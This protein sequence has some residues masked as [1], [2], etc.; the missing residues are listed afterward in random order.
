VT[1][2]HRRRL[3]AGARALAGLEGRPEPDEVRLQH[4]ASALRAA[5]RAGGGVVPRPEFE[6]LALDFGEWRVRALQTEQL[7]EGALEALERIAAGDEG[8]PSSMRDLA[9]ATAA[10]LRAALDARS[11]PEER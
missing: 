8:K 5:D 3:E 6:Q 1:D 9:F 10:E 4:M 11:S 7:L 2:W